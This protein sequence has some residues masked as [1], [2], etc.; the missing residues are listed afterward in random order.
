[1]Y[2]MRGSSVFWGG[3]AMLVLGLVV[4]IGS[5]ALAEINGGGFYIVSIGFIVAGIINM[6][7]GAPALFA[8]KKA[9]LPTA[10]TTMRSPQATQ[11]PGGYYAG[12]QPGYPQLG[13]P[14]YPAQPQPGY[15][16]SEERRVGKSVNRGG[17]RFI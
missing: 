9:Q 4:T 10:S 17:V 1:M 2:R 8:A 11:Q 12:Q 3:L 13:Q 15:G 14:G 7:R 16:R 5:L 6:I